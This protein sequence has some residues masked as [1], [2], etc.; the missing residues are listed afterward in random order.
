MWLKVLDAARVRTYF[1]DKL[2]T[3]KTLACKVPFRQG[4]ANPSSRT[5]E[6]RFYISQK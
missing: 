3:W 5:T 4:R 1:A 6:D 2:G